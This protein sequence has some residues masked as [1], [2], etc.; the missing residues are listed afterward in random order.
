VWKRQEQFP[1]DEHEAFALS[2]RASSTRTRCTNTPKGSATRS[3]G[4]TSSRSERPP[5]SS[6][7]DQGRIR[8]FVEP[9]QGGTV[10]DRRRR[11]DRTR[12]GLQ[13]RLRHRPCH[14]GTRRRVLRQSRSRHLRER[15]ALPRPP[16]QHG[17]IAIETSGGFGEA[18]IIALRD[19]VTGRPRY[20]NLY[21]HVMSSR[22]D[23]VPG[24]E[25]VRVPDEHEDAAADP[26][27]DGAA[28]AGTDVAVRDE[29]PVA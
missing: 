14:H 8:E 3:A 10:R 12:H 21:R 11:R 6:E 27:P 22:P 20:P 7:H 13:R 17:P 9:H 25:D 15:P 19:G 1:R 28:F 18:V 16:V 24:S 5:A 2:D 23:D 26:E 29:R 4:T